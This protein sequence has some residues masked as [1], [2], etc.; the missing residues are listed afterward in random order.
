MFEALIFAVRA[1]GFRPRA[2]REIDDGADV[3]IDKIMKIIGEC[4]YGIHDLSRTEVDPNTEL[5][6][7]N[8]PLELGIYLGGRRFGDEEQKKKST[9]ILDVELFRYRNFI[10][11]LAGM[12]IH[13]HAGDP[14]QAVREAR[15]WL[16]TAS[17]RRL[18]SANV[19]A[20]EYERFIADLP[21]IAAIDG[22]EVDAIPY[23][24]FE[25]IVTAWLAA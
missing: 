14:I 13:A 24:D 12:D 2:A 15:D 5:P 25:W 3:R 10:S 17:R 7:F 6:R 4:R 23:I 1:L 19:V 22:F 11:D 9:L 18:S 8:M 20:S 16:A 21:E